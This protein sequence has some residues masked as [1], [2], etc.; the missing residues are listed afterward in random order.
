MGSNSRIQSENDEKGYRKVKNGFELRIVYSRSIVVFASHSRLNVFTW[1]L[2][3][4]ITVLIKKDNDFGKL[5]SMDVY[6]HICALSKTLKCLT[7]SST[8]CI[9]V[10]RCGIKVWKQMNSVGF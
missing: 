5:V 2:L 3:K 6:F 8:F 10:L 1:I 7:V 4:K 9:I